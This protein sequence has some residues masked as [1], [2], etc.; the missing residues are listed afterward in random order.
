MLIRLV[1]I[2][3]GFSVLA[4]PALAC[5]CLCDQGAGPDAARSWLDKAAYVFRGAVISNQNQDGPKNPEAMEVVI[6]LKPTR[7]LK[8]EATGDLTVHS[9]ANGAMCGVE[10]KKGETQDVIAFGE[11][12]KLSVNLC[13]QVCASRDGVFRLLEK[14]GRPLK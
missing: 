12:G 8:G 11:N 13:G 3:A 4:P 2:V 5:S 14:D 1:V 10:W 6:R 9:P 7:I